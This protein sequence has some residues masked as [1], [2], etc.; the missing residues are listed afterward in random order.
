M[1]GLFLKVNQTFR[2]K[3]L[4]LRGGVFKYEKVMRSLSRN[5]H[6]SQGSEQQWACMQCYVPDF[7]QSIFIDRFYFILN[8]GGGGGC[9]EYYC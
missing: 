5:I 3:A 2:L 7:I 9:N 1:T 4:V 6:S 8:W